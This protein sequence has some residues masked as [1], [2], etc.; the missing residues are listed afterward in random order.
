MTNDEKDILDKEKDSINTAK[1]T[2]ESKEELTEAEL[3]QVAGGVN[4]I[5][6]F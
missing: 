6:D 2:S 3:D 5:P 4:H 1:P